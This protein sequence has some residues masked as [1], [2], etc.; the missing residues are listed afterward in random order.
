MVFV[1]VLV[2]LISLG[3]PDIVS[4]EFADEVKP[5]QC[6]IGGVDAL[7][8]VVVCV[9]KNLGIFFKLMSISTTIRVVGMVLFTPFLIALAYIIISLIR[10]GG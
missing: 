4:E 6:D 10:G 2:F 1:M 7:I 9:A 3:A 8:D 5:P